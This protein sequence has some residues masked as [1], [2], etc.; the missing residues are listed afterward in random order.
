MPIDAYSFRGILV[1]PGGLKLL[2][3][4]L[5]RSREAS[6]GILGAHISGDENCLQ[7]ASYRG[8]LQAILGVSSSGAENCSRVAS[9]RGGL[10]AILGASISK[11]ENCLQVASCRGG[12]QAILVSGCL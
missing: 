11:G 4:D 2:L 5:W 9:C 7:V 1:A 6:D 12:L 10:R 3:G 8:G